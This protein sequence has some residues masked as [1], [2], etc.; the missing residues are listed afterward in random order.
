MERLQR[1]V[2]EMAARTETSRHR[3]RQ[4]TFVNEIEELKYEEVRSCR[5]VS[6]LPAR[7][8]ERVR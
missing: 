4:L 1:V 2:G 6:R 5:V 3:P 8:P 7:L